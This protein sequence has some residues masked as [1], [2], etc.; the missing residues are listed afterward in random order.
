MQRKESE[1]LNLR[2]TRILFDDVTLKGILGYI[3]NFFSVKRFKFLPLKKKK[4]KKKVV[5]M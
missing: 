1:M 4:K 2:D 5:Q 3:P